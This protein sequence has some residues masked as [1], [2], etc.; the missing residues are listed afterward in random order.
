MSDTIEKEGLREYLEE[1]R[2]HLRKAKAG[3]E[4]HRSDYAELSGAVKAVNYLL[5][6]LRKG[7]L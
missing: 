6:E 1:Y 7:K 2:K 5:S 4:P 3:A